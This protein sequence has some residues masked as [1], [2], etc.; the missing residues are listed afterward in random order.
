MVERNVMNIQCKPDKPWC[1]NISSVVYI[2]AMKDTI[3]VL[4]SVPVGE[5]RAFLTTYANIL[6]L[7]NIHMDY[8]CNTVNK[9]YIYF[10][11]N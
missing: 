8:F 4:T 10:V 5:Y 7:L 3:H 9:L 2:V 6:S 11:G 1:F